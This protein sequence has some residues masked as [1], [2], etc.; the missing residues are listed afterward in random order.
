M[1]T[2]CYTNKRRILAEASIRKVQYPG[3]I[4]LNNNPIYS[5]IN[6]KVDFKELI[7]LINRCC[8]R[9]TFKTPT[10]VTQILSIGG[11][12]ASSSINNIL[13]GGN[14]STTSSDIVDAGG[15]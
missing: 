9:N 5:S 14:A 15:A 10:P 2:Q 6:C 13:D 3:S 7:Y 12:R 4:G 11:G 8:V 1:S